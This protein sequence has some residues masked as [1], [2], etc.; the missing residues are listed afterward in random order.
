[1]FLPC[2]V[3]LPSWMKVVAV[4]LFT[5]NL[6]SVAIF[7]PPLSLTTSFFT[8]SVPVGAVPGRTKQV[9]LAMPR[10][11]HSA[12]L[13]MWRT[14]AVGTEAVPVH[15]AVPILTVCPL[16]SMLVFSPPGRENPK[17]LP[18]LDAVQELPSAPLRS[19]STV[20]AVGIAVP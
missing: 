3:S 1:M 9:A 13:L 4:P 20:T 16:S 15:V 19:G 10:R 18:G 14:I 17:F 2:S 5:L 12:A 8:V 7:V 6:K 11:A